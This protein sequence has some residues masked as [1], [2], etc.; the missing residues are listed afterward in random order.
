MAIFGFANLDRQQLLAHHPP[1]IASVL[2]LY[3]NGRTRNSN[4]FQNG[5]NMEVSLFGV[6]DVFWV[7]DG[8]CCQ[9]LLDQ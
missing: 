4:S 9:L 5:G 2:L 7:G 8:V 6:G 3:A 1:R